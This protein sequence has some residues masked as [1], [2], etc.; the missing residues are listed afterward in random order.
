M[1]YS[2]NMKKVTGLDVMTGGKKTYPLQIDF[3]YF[4]SRVNLN[5]P[6]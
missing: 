2:Q 5:I 6:V 3:K 4:Q 1:G